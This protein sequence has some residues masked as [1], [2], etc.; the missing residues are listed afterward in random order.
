MNYANLEEVT[1]KALETGEKIVSLECPCC[2]RTYYALE[3]E[4][5]Y[6]RVNRAEDDYKVDPERFS[7]RSLGRKCPHCGFVSSLS[8]SDLL[9]SIPKET[10]Q[11]LVEK[12]TPW[13]VI[14]N[15]GV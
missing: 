7:L 15:M 9:N 10:K 4:A 12:E 8:P 11:E 6:E 2:H 14:N 13:S 1:N 3:R 5:M